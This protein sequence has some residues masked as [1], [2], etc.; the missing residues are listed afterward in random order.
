MTEGGVDTEGATGTD[1]PGGGLL[2]GRTVPT[3]PPGATPTPGGS[4]SPTPDPT[5]TPT[6]E[7]TPTPTPAPT[8]TPT[9]TPDPT[10]TPT[11]DPTP[12][13]P[14]AAFDFDPNGLRVKFSDGSANAVS[15][16]WSFGDGAT[17]G[18]RHPSH[19]YGEPGTYSV[20]LTVTASGGAT[21]S[22]T[23]DVTVGG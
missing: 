20:R 3:P 6:P 11:P 22:V 8:P 17:S 13:P 18:G 7:A 21:D 5:A 19:T 9:P 4:G 2:P 15:W 14:S 23:R 16:S 12:P 1:A 10:P